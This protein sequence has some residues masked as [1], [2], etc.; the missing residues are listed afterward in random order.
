ME[1][2]GIVHP[3]ITPKTQNT[4]P[5]NKTANCTKSDIVDNNKLEIAELDNDFRKQAA[6]QVV[7]KLNS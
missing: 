4:Q 1:K 6:A 2:M 3:D 7:R 5:E